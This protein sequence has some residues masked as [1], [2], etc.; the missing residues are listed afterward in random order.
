MRIDQILGSPN[1]NVGPSFSVFS[2]Y[3]FYYCTASR[4]IF[5]QVRVCGETPAP[6]PF[7]ARG[8]LCIFGDDTLMLCVVRCV[9]VFREM[10]L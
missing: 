6:P 4:G 5:T 2:S 9:L 3:R 10:L 1:K 8:N 7:S